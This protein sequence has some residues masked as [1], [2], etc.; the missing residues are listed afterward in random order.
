MNSAVVHRKIILLLLPLCTL[1]L[2]GGCKSSAVPRTAPR[3]TELARKDNDRAFELIQSGK[4]EQAETLLRKAVAADV[5]FGPARNNLGLVYY[6]TGKL[7]QAAWEFQNAIKLM[8]FQPE[9]RNNLGLVLE[10]AGKL[11]DAADAYDRARQ[12]EPDNP[13]YIGNLA[14]AKV[15]RGDSDRETRDLLEE[16]VF[17]DSRTAWS[18]W[19]KEN[20]FRLNRPPDDPD[21][22][23]T[24]PTNP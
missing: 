22:P 13:E 1:P 6:H 5:M 4:Y 2:A 7:Y 24:G 12:M 9:P 8:P 16:V 23:T 19:A 20:L 10:R 17:K 18:S 15:R 21:A 11:T 3:D 14:R